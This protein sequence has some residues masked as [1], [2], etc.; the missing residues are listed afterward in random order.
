MK[1]FWLLLAAVAAILAAF[2]LAG[3]IPMPVLY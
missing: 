1:K 2:W 3:M